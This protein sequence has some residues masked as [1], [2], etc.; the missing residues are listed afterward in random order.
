M[1]AAAWESAR[2]PRLCAHGSKAEG[3]R[4]FCL[5]LLGDV[6][7][8]P[9]HAIL[10]GEAP[11]VGHQHTPSNLEI[12]ARC[13]SLTR[14]KQ[15]PWLRNTLLS[16]IVLM[17]EDFVRG[18]LSKKHVRR[19]T[20]RA[21]DG[22][23]V[24]LDWWEQDGQCVD[25]KKAKGVVFIASTFTGEAIVCVTRTACEYYTKMG[26]I[27]VVFVKRGCGLVM[28]NTLTES[29]TEGKPAPWCLTGLADIKMSID[30]VAKLYPDLPLVGLGFSGGACQLRNY[31]RVLGKESKLAAAALL[32][33]GHEWSSG[34]HSVDRKNPVYAKALAGAAEATYAAAGHPP[35]PVSEDIKGKVM[36]GGLVEFVCNRMAPEHGY[37]RSLA[38]GEAYMQACNTLHP[39]HT[40][41]PVLEMLSLQD[42]ILDAETILTVHSS[43]Q[44]SPNIMTVTTREGTH[45][46]RWEGLRPRCWVT[47]ASE[48]FFVAALKVLREGV[49]APT[50]EAAPAAVQASRRQCLVECTV[51]RTPSRPRLGSRST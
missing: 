1:M 39:S 31:V 15:T 37:E 17:L 20:L 14:F 36:P 9:L 22:G 49:E 13:P 2:Y 5:Q 45:A 33:A 7:L 43:Y 29:T 35:Q 41:I 42:T 26:W 32:D 38:G 48:E 6:L 24:A 40:T 3:L 47:R 12:L 50:A 27:V 4:T 30:H 46:L 18:P 44:A 19:E 25:A 23:A 21:P 28:P 34:L 11:M 8:I 16:F 10:P 51:Q